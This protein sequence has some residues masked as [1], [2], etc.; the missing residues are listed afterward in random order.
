MEKP[1]AVM[2]H[3]YALAK[4]CAL[5]L[6]SITVMGG[7]SVWEDGAYL[8]WYPNEDK[9][10]S[11]EPLKK[12][13]IAYK[14]RTERQHG[15]VWCRDMPAEYSDDTANVLRHR[16][17]DNEYK[18]YVSLIVLKLYNCQY[19]HNGLS[20]D[21]NDNPQ[22]LKDFNLTHGAFV[23]LLAEAGYGIENPLTGQVVDYLT[24]NPAL[25]KD[26][27]IQDELRRTCKLDKRRN[28]KENWS[29]CVKLL[30]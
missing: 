30:R 2:K 7:A 1:V 16:T 17:I 19:E 8:R 4:L 24:Q 29:S 3:L 11:I 27:Y 6:L 10:L 28:Y 9:S 20:E 23:K 26:A 22:S 21:F 13:A 15:V 14:P 5:L 18:L 12:F 25:L